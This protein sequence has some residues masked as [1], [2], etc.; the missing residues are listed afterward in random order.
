MPTVYRKT[1]KGAAE[2]ATRA[3]HLAPR[4][5]SA[6]IVVDGKRSSAELVKLIPGSGEEALLTLLKAGYIEPTTEPVRLAAG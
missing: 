1:T 3:N 6:L 4:L 2:I 5:R